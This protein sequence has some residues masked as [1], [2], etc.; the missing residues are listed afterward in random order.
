MDPSLLI[1]PDIC[2]ECKSNFNDAPQVEFD[3]EECMAFEITEPIN[4]ASHSNRR[5]TKMTVQQRT[6]RALKAACENLIFFC[7]H[8]P[9]LGEV[10]TN[11]VISL[12]Q[13]LRAGKMPHVDLIQPIFQ[14]TEA[15]NDQMI[16]NTIVAP[17][18]PLTQQPGRKIKKRFLSTAAGETR[19]KHLKGRP[20]QKRKHTSTTHDAQTRVCKICNMEGS[21]SRST[22][23]CSALAKFGYVIPKSEYQFVLNME[24]PVASDICC[25]DVCSLNIPQT[26]QFTHLIIEH[27]HKDRNGMKYCAVSGLSAELLPEWQHKLFTMTALHSFMNSIHKNHL[28]QL[29]FRYERNSA[30]LTVQYVRRSSPTTPVPTAAMNQRVRLPGNIYLLHN[31]KA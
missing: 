14:S 18:L 29:C 16:T 24:I 5:A 1:F 8:S 19:A 4:E 2:A 30:E 10:A 28:R 20:S 9:Q 15:H 22:H 17:P 7:S 6:Y 12:E 13:S 25:E 27:L 26:A 21:C 11:A 23:K 3:G 31:G